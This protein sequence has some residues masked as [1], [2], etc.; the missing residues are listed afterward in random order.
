MNLRSVFQRLMNIP[1]L[2]PDDARR[3]KLLNLILLTVTGFS[4]LLFVGAAL[5]IIPRLLGGGGVI[6]DDLMLLFLGS[7]GMVIGGCF[8]FAINRYW[9]G[10]V[11]SVLFLGLFTL[12]SAFS[13][14]PEQVANGRSLFIFAIP[15]L[16]A[17]VILRPYASFIFA[18]LCSLI[19]ALIGISIDYAPNIPAMIGFFSVA[20]VS[21]LS[22]RTLEQALADLR[23]TNREL[24]RRVAM[25]THDLAEALIRVQTES[26]KNQAILESIADGVI[27]FDATSTAAI[28]NPAITQLLGLPA[29]DILGRSIMALTEQHMADDDREKMAVLLRGGM[30]EP[31]AKLRWDNKTLS[32]SFAPIL[33]G[34][35]HHSG[36][37]VVFRDFTREAEL[38]RMKS[39]FVSMASHELRTPLNA[40]LGYTDML[41]VGVYGALSDD[42]QNALERIAANTKRMLGL[43][44][45]LLDQAQIEA[46]KL[47]LYIGPFAIHDLLADLEATM[48][49]LAISKGVEFSYTVENLPDVLLGDPQRLNQILVN[50]VGNAIKFTDQGYVRVRAYRHDET[51]WALQVSDTG[52]GIPKEAHSYIFEAFRQVDDP[53]TRKYTGSGL[54]LSI[55]KQLTTLMGGEITLV[56]DVGQGSTFTI[57]LPLN[58]IQEG[59]HERATT[60]AGH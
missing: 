24:D 2:D 25:R 35:E 36:T 42:Q 31:S 9:S 18:G 59:H 40:I 26:G 60:G 11:A 39:A 22:A 1:V 38:D 50:L 32:V 53:I 28:A 19:V 34:S 49:V 58:P 37:V 41:K 33:D 48:G 10:V 52:A 15:I 47:T 27:V 55:V 13:D 23:A 17:S 6:P 54:G 44:N 12:M 5:A 51:H 14:N 20:L 8:I 46:G 30:H 43:V 21:W 3:R 4:L 57:I 45:N 56:S 29:E 7:L 16:M